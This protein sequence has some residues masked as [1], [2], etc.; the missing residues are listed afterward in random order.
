M[1]G[2][3]S[4]RRWG[5][6]DTTDDYRQLD[7]RWIE[8]NGYLKNGHS[9]SLHWTRRGETIAT[10]DFRVRPDSVLLSYRQRNRGE[11][12]WESLEYPVRLERT[13][14]HY[15]G[16]RSWFLCPAKGCGKRVAILYG[17]RI[18]ACRRCYGLAYSSQRE[19][20][21]DRATD[22]AWG[23]LKR[24]GCDKFMSVLDSDPPRPKGMHMRTYLRL[25]KRYEYERGESFYDMAVR[26]GIT[27]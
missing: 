13:P 11:S 25:H 2:W 7:V 6:R 5:G 9:G 22:R 21:S 3:G 23:I 26:F 12:D 4:G 16:T 24:L 14:C 15:G 27:K 19:S 1:G 18:F 20:R 10:I 17:G 8:R